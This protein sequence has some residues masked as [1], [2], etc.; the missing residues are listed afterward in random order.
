MYDVEVDDIVDVKVCIK[1]DGEET[2]E[3]LDQVGA[4]W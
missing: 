3:Q 4:L 1:C 2:G